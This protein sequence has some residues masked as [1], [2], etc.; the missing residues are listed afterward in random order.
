ME[1]HYVVSST[2]NVVAV[3][4]KALREHAFE[5]AARYRRNGVPCEVFTRAGKKLSTGGHYN[6]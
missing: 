5:S 1:Y 6:A 3:Y 2:G 4:G